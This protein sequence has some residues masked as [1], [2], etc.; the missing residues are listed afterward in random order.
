MGSGKS[1]YIL[2]FA[3]VFIVAVAVGLS[4]AVMLWLTGWL[5]DCP[6]LVG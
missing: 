5:K 4:A 2:S 6:R 3:F 1:I